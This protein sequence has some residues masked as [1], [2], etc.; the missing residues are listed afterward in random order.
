MR[1]LIFNRNKSHPDVTGYHI[2]NRLDMGSHAGNSGV[3]LHRF[4]KIFNQIPDTGSFMLQNERG[5][6]KMFQKLCTGKRTLAVSA[7]FLTIGMAAGSGKDNLFFL[8][9][10][11]LASVLFKRIG[12]Y[13]C[14]V[15]FTF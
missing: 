14:Q 1:R 4:K 2:T 8:Q 6:L 12:S 15:Y 5:T 10:N 7:G 13:K 9:L 11:A 3:K